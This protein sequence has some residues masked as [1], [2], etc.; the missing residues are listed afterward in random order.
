[1]EDHVHPMLSRLSLGGGSCG[2]WS[3]EDAHREL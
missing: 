2:Y 3:R 1:M